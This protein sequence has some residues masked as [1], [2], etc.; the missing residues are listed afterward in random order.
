MAEVVG[1]T[2]LYAALKQVGFPIPEECGDIALVL[3]VDGIM[4]LRY[5]TFVTGENLVKLAEA[6]KLI[7]EKD[8][9]VLAASSFGD[10]LT[11]RMMEHGRETALDLVDKR[12]AL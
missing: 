10:G 7:G 12:S 2:N 6:L 11:K 8:P 5:S 9:T 1:G 3:P 4:M